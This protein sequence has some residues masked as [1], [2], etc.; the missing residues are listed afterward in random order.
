ML[1]ALTGLIV[2]L[3]VAAAL[4][5]PSK[6]V[7]LLDPAQDVSGPLDIRRAGLSLAADGRLRAIVTFAGKVTP[8]DLLASSGPPGSACLRIWTAADADPAA[9]RPDHLVCVTADKD[10]NLRAGVFEQRDAGLP[11]RAGAASLTANPSGR[12]FIIRVSQSALGRPELI[13]FVVESTNPGCARVSCI[14][15]APDT[16]AAR[17]FRVRSA[18]PGAA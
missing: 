9:M 14:D 12:S 13:R 18:A 17:R 8:Q 2:A 10:A 16:G 4:A 7:V 5:A 3:A 1:C 11:Q 6:Q 15:T